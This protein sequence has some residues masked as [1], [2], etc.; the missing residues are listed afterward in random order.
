[1]TNMARVA[2]SSNSVYLSPVTG[3]LQL[4][5]LVTRVIGDR[6]M[7][8]DAPHKYST[9]QFWLKFDLKNDG[10]PNGTFIYNR[11]ASHAIVNK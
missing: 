9:V 6:R 1:M 3:Q 8:T 7:R 10:L 2:S 11:S 5:W 4:S